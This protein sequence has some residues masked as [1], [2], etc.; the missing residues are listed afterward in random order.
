MWKLQFTLKYNLV[1][2]CN[3]LNV[4]AF[5]KF[6]CW[7]SNPNVKGIERGDLQEPSSV[8]LVP[9]LRDQCP[10]YGIREFIR[11]GL[12]EPA[13]AL[14]SL[15]QNKSSVC[16]PESSHRT[17]LCWHSDFRVPVSG[18]VREKKIGCIN[19]FICKCSQ[20]YIINFNRRI[21]FKL[22]QKAIHK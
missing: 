22:T 10:S 11:R 2:L 6:I 4:F 12:R 19:K 8:G 3:G 18:T 16:T 5:P 17:G 21:H 9:F 14:T 15:W 1:M 20:S 13:S 7:N